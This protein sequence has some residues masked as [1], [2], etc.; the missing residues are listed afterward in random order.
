[1]L[2]KNENFGMNNLSNNYTLEAI[3]LLSKMSKDVKKKLLKAKILKEDEDIANLIP[4]L[5]ESLQSNKKGLD[6]FRKSNN[7]NDFLTKLWVSKVKEIAL[8]QLLITENLKEFKGISKKDL[9]IISAYSSD[10]E[11][12]T[13]IKKILLN[14]Y[15]ILLYFIHNIEGMKTDAVTFKLSTGTPI[16][17][18]SLRFPQYDRFWFTL[19][20]E[21]SHICLHYD[22][23]DEPIIDNN[24]D[25]GDSIH[26]IANIENEA[27][28]L[29]RISLV[30]DK[31]W[32]KCRA[33]KKI[34]DTLLLEF[35]N[36]N[37]LHPSIIAGFIKYE[38]KKYYLYKNFNKNIV[39]EKLLEN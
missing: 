29:A 14:E 2:N 12:Y 32:K 33:R 23:L 22:L 39:R 10:T 8:K 18:M 21:L 37:K 24:Y 38:Q 35:C 5:I 3:K 7:S 11:N 9:S 27:D 6:L 34:N 28:D 30:S 19:M 16:I 17:G 4:L 26:D 25:A 31:L 13:K 36:D 20:H 1:M 15:G